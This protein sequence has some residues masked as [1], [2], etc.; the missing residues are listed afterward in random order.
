MA[1]GVVSWW[2]RKLLHQPPT[3]AEWGTLSSKIAEQIRDAVKVERA[4]CV[5]IVEIRG[6]GWFIEGSRPMPTLLG[7]IADSIKSGEPAKSKGGE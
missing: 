3:G 4:R 1:E 6:A 7:A 5:A 2:R